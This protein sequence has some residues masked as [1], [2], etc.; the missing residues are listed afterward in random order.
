MKMLEL[1]E[2]LQ[3]CDE[4]AEVVFSDD[5]FGRIDNRIPVDRLFHGK[6]KDGT[7]TIVLMPDEKPANQQ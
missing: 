7:Y 3:G 5:V 1:L 2:A 4:T 6:N